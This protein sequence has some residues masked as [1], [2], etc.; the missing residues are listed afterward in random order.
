MSKKER[1]AQA[2][3]L[4][5]LVSKESANQAPWRTITI[6]AVLKIQPIPMALRSDEDDLRDVSKMLSEWLTHDD[7][8]RYGTDVQ[9]CS[10]NEG[11]TEPARLAGAG[12]CES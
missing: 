8:G 12:E 2:D 9:F 5:A 6:V 3:R 7:I 11:L 10:V 1:K 4:A